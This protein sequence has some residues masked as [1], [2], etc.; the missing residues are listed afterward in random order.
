M[1]RSQ[2]AFV[3]LMTIDLLISA[4]TS[5]KAKR[6]VVKSIIHQLRNK[7]NLS[8]AEID[9]LDRWQR[10]L[11]GLSMVSNDQRLIKQTAASVESFVREF[12]EVQLLDITIEVL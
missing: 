11:I 1:S 12:H 9:F 6:S 7:Y 10:A 3:L 5:L 4:S 8:V 2:N